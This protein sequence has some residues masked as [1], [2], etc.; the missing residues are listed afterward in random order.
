M[1]SPRD[2]W[3]SLGKSR[4]AKCSAVRWRRLR[5][6]Q[7]E[8]RRL[9][10]IATLSPT[11]DSARYLVQDSGASVLA[12]EAA[13]EAYQV[14]PVTRL[15][16][17]NY[18]DVEPDVF[19]PNVVWA[20]GPDPLAPGAES[21]NDE[22]SSRSHLE[23]GLTARVDVP[24]G[25][26]S[27]EE[28]AAF[29]AV[30]SDSS[31][32]SKTPPGPAED[33][34]HAN[35]V[36]TFVLDFKEVA[37]GSTFDIF[38]NEVTTFDVTSY[39]FAP[40][41]FNTVANAILA[42]VDEDYF[43]ELVGTVAGLSGQDLDV[44]FI[45]GDIGT[46]PAGVTEY[47]YVQIGA[48]VA[49]PHS[50]GTLGVAGGSVVRDDST[51]TGPNLGFQVGDVVASVFTDA[52]VTLSSLSPSNALT[53]GNL[54]FTTHAISGTLSHEIGHT[55][56]LSHINKSG[57]VQPTPGVPPLMG[58]GAI[59]LPTQ[60]R[61][62][63][64]EFSLAGAD[65]QNGNAP[66]QHIQQLVDAVG[67]HSTDVLPPGVD[68][69]DVSP[70][71]R[72]SSVNTIEIR[73][74]E[75]VFGFDKED[76]RLGRDDANVPLDSATLFT[77]NDRTFNLGTLQTL[78]NI[79]GQYELELIATNS[80][81]VDA[82]DNSLLF[83]AI[84]NWEKR[85]STIGPNVDDII[86]VW[87]DPRNAPVEYVDV[88][89]S[90]SVDEAT[91]TFDDVTLI[92]NGVEVA[93]NSSVTISQSGHRINGLTS[94]TSPDGIY[95]IT[96]AGAGIADPQGN[97]GSGVAS[98]SWVNGTPP[99]ALIEGVKWH[100]L[101]GDGIRDGGEPGMAGWTIYID[102]NDN[103]Q[104]DAGETSA[105]T[106]SSG[107]YLL[108]NLD[109][110]DY[111]INE[112]LQSGWDQTFPVGQGVLYFSEDHNSDGLYRLNTSNGFA[113]Q[114]ASTGAAGANVGLAATDDPNLLL[115][116]LPFESR[117]ITVDDSGFFWGVNGYRQGLT[118]D[119]DD[120]IHYAI[121][122]QS[123]FTV[124]SST[125]ALISF[126]PSPPFGMQA[127]AYG[128][129][130]VYGWGSGG[131]L[132]AFDIAANQWTSIGFTS[133]FGGNYG[134]AY[135]NFRDILY[136]V[137]DD[138]TSLYEIDPLTAQATVIGDTGINE[139]GGLAFVG[140]A[141]TA[142]DVSIL[143]GQL[144][145]LNFGNKLTPDAVTPSVNVTAPAFTSDT[146]PPVT[147]SASDNFTLPDGTSV[148][149]DVDLNDNGDFADAGEQD[150]AIGSLVSES[151][152]IDIVPGLAEGVYRVRARVADQS[153]NE[154]TSS[155]AVIVI[156]TTPPS[157]VLNA[158][159]ITTDATPEVS[160]S[161]ADNN[162]L[163]DGTTVLLD[164]DLN[165]DGDFNDAGEQSYTTS[166]L[167]GNVASFEI[168]PA[169]ST[170]DYR[171]RV[172]IVDQAG[173]Q[174]TSESIPISI[175][176]DQLD[177]GD[178]PTSAQSGFASSYPTQLPDGA[179]HAATGPLLGSNR[180][181]EADGQPDA[182][183]LGDDNNGTP[184]D[185][186]GV[187][188]SPLIPGQP[189]TMTVVVD[190]G[191]GVVEAWVDFNRD[192]VWQHPAEQVFAGLLA[193]G[194]HQLQFA[195]PQD[196]MPGTSF[197][198]VRISS[199]GGLTL[200]GLAADGEVEDDQLTIHSYVVARQ[201]FYNN[202]KWDGHT[203]FED[204]DPAANEFDD[205]AI[206]TDKTALLPGQTAT[207]ANYTS[208]HRG[209]NGVMIDVDGLADP[210]AVGD[211]DL[212]EFVFR[213]GNGNDLTEWLP[214]PDPVDVDVRDMGEGVYRVTIT[215]ADNAI[216]NKN[217]LQVTVK[218]DAN[219]GLE[220]DDVFY[221]GNSSGENTGD[222]RVDYDDVFDNIWPSLFTPEEIGV[223]DAGD[224]NRDKRIDYSDVFDA[225]WP[226]LFGPAPLVQLTAPAAPAAPLEATDFVFDENRPWAIE[227]MW[228][229]ALYG[230][231]SSSEEEED[232]P[233]EA[234]AVDGFFAGYYEE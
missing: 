109:P 91:F 190:G 6:E 223:E 126:L 37:Q 167:T 88:T 49:G 30:E 138:D 63:D 93:L 128:R 112:V 216:P 74:S 165:N 189:A 26:F 121:N 132:A 218:A 122:N 5:F 186:D 168:M 73:F 144:L 145:T 28:I 136:G 71:P 133:I 172:R 191:G 11:D 197:A 150:Y 100:D 124:N 4:S 7:F 41:G 231:S 39:G 135:D 16:D 224:V 212:G 204:G 44:D 208:Y 222:F 202:S 220:A 192:G 163:P 51:G 219:T 146:T 31:F 137:A 114:I 211:D 175:I 50:D 157:V 19:G 158:A 69:I 210:D 176:D 178:A 196:A 151:A 141:P 171:M 68:I 3:S 58:T 156:D 120:D 123:F 43:T 206:A 104:F 9:L 233:L 108:P 148:A 64:R 97:F 62:G 139:G 13:V 170:G 214:A 160:V 56:S 205:A 83:G 115:A 143:P 230:T 85:T 15:T 101:D 34:G 35:E 113:T 162:V 193:D 75:A 105:V 203:G 77:S 17:N 29:A 47:Y 195:V 1:I 96:V 134:L 129:V 142:H 36:L 48:G 166:Q 161:A 18:D 117:L 153:G 111:V 226:N 92:R 70:D 102:A 99:L 40:G 103:G 130:K 185:E 22:P 209:I 131:R 125:G 173:I 225:V 95:E 213:Y 27:P 183:A 98:D 12:G 80:G 234:T 127:V 54:T 201:I 53:S 199:S 8:D 232:D 87:P 33:G 106:D 32:S 76:L 227:L 181:T 164:V 180:D 2:L 147:V 149:L 116:T 229:D 61:I 52:I 107:N 228:F 66:R 215:W 23:G 21:N 182:N 84:E 57:S 184:N 20:G 154:G 25:V 14:S 79:D 174:G 188:F 38:A 140:H 59:D 82:N 217:W 194:T 179:R 155:V 46:A 42:E 86:D 177:F 89:F 152:I 60:D 118:Y 221:F 119:F 90:E 94:F 198:R 207:F 110:G 45:I 169:L 24:L 81:I 187:S 159:L 72:N 67:L 78:T 200:T 10:S 65:G 55:L